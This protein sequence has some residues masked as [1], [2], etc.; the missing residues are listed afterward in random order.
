MKNN[1][2]KDSACRIRNLFFGAVLL[3]LG[4]GLLLASC[5]DFYST[6]W[7][8][9]FARDPSN[10][11]V[12][13]SNVDEL[14][15]DASG[16]REAS[17][18]ILKKLIGTD[19]P[20]LQAA[21]VKAANQAAGLTELA[22]SNLGTLTG[23]NADNADSLEK[24]AKTIMAEAREND[25]KGIADDIAGTLPVS[26]SNPPQFR[27][28]FADSVSSSDLTLLLVTMMLAEVP[29]ENEFDDYVDEWGSGKKIDGTGNINLDE[30]EKVIAA[31]ANEVIG[32]RVDSELGKMLGSLVGAR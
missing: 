15:K 14:L 11:K 19:D 22:L 29:E 4:T 31:V 23:S 10:V 30:K 1:I 25:I 6:T 2:G 3:A 16:D 12:T 9:A 7:G 32:K 28:S 18:A 26:S 21:A 5:S 24:L 27:G 8:E 20:K 17:R 13:S